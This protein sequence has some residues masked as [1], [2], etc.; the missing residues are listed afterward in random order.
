MTL[1]G[2]LAKVVWLGPVPADECVLSSGRPTVRT[3]PLPARPSQGPV[4][5]GLQVFPAEWKSDGEYTKCCRGQTFPEGDTG[6]GYS[7]WVLKDG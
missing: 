6:K 4:Q 2:Q 3:W 7:S 1:R 5:T